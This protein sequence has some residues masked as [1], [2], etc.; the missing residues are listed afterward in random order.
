MFS[1][2][3]WPDIEQMMNAL[4]RYQTSNEKYHFFVTIAEF[5]PEQFSLLLPCLCIFADETIRIDTGIANC[6][7]LV[8]SVATLQPASKELT[9]CDDA[10]RLIKARLQQATAIFMRL[11][12]GGGMEGQNDRHGREMTAKEWDGFGAI[13]DLYEIR[14]VFFQMLDHFPHIRLPACS[15]DTQ[16]GDVADLFLRQSAQGEFTVYGHPISIRIQSFRHLFDHSLD[17]TGPVCR[18]CKLARSYD[19]DMDWHV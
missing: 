5:I 1:D 10:I 4:D 15:R 11:N 2:N 7:F 3:R 6:C 16:M 14:F 12:K 17:G 19:G 13:I 8:T 9:V 18:S